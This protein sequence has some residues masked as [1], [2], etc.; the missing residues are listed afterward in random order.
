MTTKRT[1]KLAVTTVVWVTHAADADMWQL[2]HGDPAR[3]RMSAARVTA[4]T[5]S[6]PRE[7]DG[8]PFPRRSSACPSS[9]AS[10]LEPGSPQPPEAIR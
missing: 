6:W 1:C 3:R 8:H 10:V 5:P 7:G 4:G 2:R 9:E